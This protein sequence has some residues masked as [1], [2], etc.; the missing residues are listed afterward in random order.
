MCCFISSVYVV[1]L[2]VVQKRK[3]NPKPTLFTCYMESK[4]SEL[5]SALD[6]FVNMDTFYSLQH[7]FN[8]TVSR[9]ICS[10]TD[11]LHLGVSPDVRYDY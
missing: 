1:M 10:L 3:K 8:A 6:L 4:I 11:K 5:I 9:Q 2:R 7:N